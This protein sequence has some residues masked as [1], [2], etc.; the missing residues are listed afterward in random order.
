VLEIGGGN[1]L[2]SMFVSGFGTVDVYEKNE[3]SLVWQKILGLGQRITLKLENY[4]FQDIG[5]YDL[6]T[7]IE[8][9]EHVESPNSYLKGARAVLEDDGYGY[10]TFAVRMP[11]VDHIQQFDSIEECK[12]LIQQC[13][14]GVVEDFCTIL[15]YVPFD[16]DERWS[17]AADPNYAVTYCCVVE[18]ET[19]ND[20]DRLVGTFNDQ[21]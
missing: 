11:Q 16:D 5:K 20:I 19:E 7:M 15:N 17:L 10:L 6:V 12:N 1:C 2:D 8:L 14:F 3:L 18:K 21:L 4:C 13:G 9:L